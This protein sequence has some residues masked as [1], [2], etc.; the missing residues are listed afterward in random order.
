MTVN[1]WKF[2]EASILH[3]RSPA[4]ISGTLKVNVMNVLYF[5]VIYKV[6][7]NCNAKL[8]AALQV[9]NY[10][11]KILQ[12]CYFISTQ[13]FLSENFL[14][15]KSKELLKKNVVFRV[16]QLAESFLLKLNRPYILNL[17]SYFRKDL[18][19]KSYRQVYS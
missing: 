12:Q 19:E 16:C 18:K 6:Y 9:I 7:L 11:Y 8:T 14:L 13:T 15:K 10:R 5:F 4:N 3:S 1:I 17:I 2:S